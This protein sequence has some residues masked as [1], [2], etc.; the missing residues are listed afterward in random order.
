M[1]ILKTVMGAI[2][3]ELLLIIGAFLFVVATARVSITLTLYLV[4]IFCFA[5]GFFIAKHRR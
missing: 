4:G 1:K 5:G 3:A 2:S